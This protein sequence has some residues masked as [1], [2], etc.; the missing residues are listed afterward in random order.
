M[1]LYILIT[2]AFGLIVG[3]ITWFITHRKMKIKINDILNDWND[4]FEK[5]TQLLKEQHQV[6][7]KISDDNKLLLDFLTDIKAN[8][9]LESLLDKTDMDIK[10]STDDILEKISKT[11]INS[12]TKNENEYLNKKSKEI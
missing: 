2:I 11:G 1:V 5:D 10:Y 8:H 12:L 9:D 4:D 6:L 3:Y 7:I